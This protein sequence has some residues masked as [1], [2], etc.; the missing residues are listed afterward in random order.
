MLLPSFLPEN[1]GKALGT[2]ITAVYLG[3]SVGPFLGGIMTQY[4]GWRSIFFVNVPIGIAAILLILW[5]LKREWAE[6]RGEKFDLT[7]SVIYGAAIVAVMY[8]FST[9][10]DFKGAALLGVGIIG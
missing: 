7:G 9:L 4:L 8:G 6:C 2:Y 10:P 1:A 3:L 5:K